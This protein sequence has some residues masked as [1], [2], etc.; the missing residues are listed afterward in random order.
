MHEYYKD[1]FYLLHLYD[2]RFTEGLRHPWI[3]SQT[4]PFTFFIAFWSCITLYHL[5]CPKEGIFSPKDLSP[6]LNWEFLLRCL[7]WVPANSK[8]PEK[9]L[10]INQ[11]ARKELKHDTEDVPWPKGS[12]CSTGRKPRDLMMSSWSILNYVCYELL[13]ATVFQRRAEDLC[14]RPQTVWGLFGYYFSL[15]F[16]ASF[17][18]F[19]P[20]DTENSRSVKSLATLL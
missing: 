13:K 4:L 12:P 10:R 2:C 5:S 15:D 9:H 20:R 1:Q 19:W 6:Q 14:G 16:P 18:N 8:C 17:D 7:T 3:P 11:Y